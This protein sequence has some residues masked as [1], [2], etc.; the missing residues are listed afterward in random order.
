MIFLM[1]QFSLR[2]LS[3]FAET[4]KC[5]GI[6]QAAR[7]LNVSPAAV[8]SAI[9]K[10]EDTTGLVL[11]DRFPARGM[12]LTPTGAEFL[13][14]AEALLAQS[15]R[16]AK[17]A[18]DLAAG[19]AGSLRIGTHHAVAQNIVLPAVLAL[20][21]SHPAVR[22]EI[23]E[24]EFENLTAALENGK[25][26]ALVVFDQGFDPLRHMI[27]TLNVLDPIVLLPAVHP[28]TKKERIEI[29]DLTGLP[30][31]NVSA[32]GPGQSYLDMLRAAGLD[33][34]VPL[35]SQSRELAQA[36]VGKGLG[37]TLVAFPPRQGITIEGDNIAARPLKQSIGKVRVVI[38]QPRGGRA[39]KFASSFL[40]ACRAQI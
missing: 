31:I 18:T 3:L 24:D 33:P 25:V 35:S 8:A 10:L 26:D 21:E 30:Y 5:G 36:Y 16:L 38:A 4:A 13:A 28:L 32:S 1:L 37:F 20:R 9:D 23:V 22:I 19:D 14:D 39:T 6:A 12:R 34:E 29:K 11:F 17:H 27:E 15:R 40:Q 7:N 2:Q